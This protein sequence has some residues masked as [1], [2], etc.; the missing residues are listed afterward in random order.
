MVLKKAITSKSFAKKPMKVRNRVRKKQLLMIQRGWMIADRNAKYFDL[1]NAI[2]RNKLGLWEE[3]EEYLIEFG[4][5]TN[6]YKELLMEDDFRTFQS[7]TDAANKNN[8]FYFFKHEVYDSFVHDAEYVGAVHG[9]WHQ[10]KVQPDVPPRIKPKKPK[11]KTKRK[12]GTKNTSYLIQKIKDTARY[13]EKLFAN[14]EIERLV[15]VD[16]VIFE[17]LDTSNVAELEFDISSHKKHTKTVKRKSLLGG[18]S[19]LSVMNRKLVLEFISKSVN[20][21]EI[22]QG[23][24]FYVEKGSGQDIECSGD[25]C[26]IETGHPKTNRWIQIK[27]YIPPVD[28]AVPIIIG[29]KDFNRLG[30]HTF[31]KLERVEGDVDRKD[32]ANT[33]VSRVTLKPMNPLKIKKRFEHFAN[34]ELMG[35]GE[36]DDEDILYQMSVGM[37][38]RAEKP[39]DVASLRT[40]DDDWIEEDPDKDQLMDLTEIKGKRV[41]VHVQQ[42]IRDTLQSLFD[43]WG[44]AAAMRLK[45]MLIKYY[46]CL[47]EHKFDFGTFNGLEYEIPLNDEWDGKAIRRNSYNGQSPDDLELA[48][49]WCNEPVERGFLE[50]YRVPCGCAGF[51]VTNNDGSKR[52]VIDYGPINKFTVPLSYPCPDINNVILGLQGMNCFSQF[53]ITKACITSRSPRRTGRKRR[54]SCRPAPSLGR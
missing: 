48:E 33:V 42:E 23:Q 37:R 4:K 52:L 24:R 45:R 47:S 34:R 14:R 46:L 41:A 31:I 8:R 20:K 11:A 40:A 9:N 35:L 16:R 5:L 43:D 44:M 50:R 6:N 53:H 36:K 25:F 21:L 17:K 49:A 13:Q 18:G 39:Q 3:L 2:I 27:F 22:H 51:V 28:L 19:T 54:S 10:T 7:V 29:S 1:A 15:I 30:I 32:D 26:I 38:D 12:F